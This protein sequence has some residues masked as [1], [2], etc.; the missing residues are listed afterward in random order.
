[1]WELGAGFGGG[2]RHTPGPGSDVLSSAADA[3]GRWD[4]VPVVCALQPAWTLPV[5]RE[6]P[7]GQVPSPCHRHPGMSPPGVKQPI[8]WEW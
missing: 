7:S 1:M 6:P 2:L 4:K 8:S 5:H 3:G